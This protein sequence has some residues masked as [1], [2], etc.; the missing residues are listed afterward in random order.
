MGAR[1]SLRSLLRHLTFLEEE[2]AILDEAVAKKAE[3][4]RY[5][6]AVERLEAMPGIRVLTAMIFLTELGDMGRFRNRRQVGGILGL[7]PSSNESGEITDRKGHITRYGSGRL[8]R[9]LC[10]AVWGRIKQGGPDRPF[11]DRLVERNPKKKMIA[12]VAC[13][14]KLGVKM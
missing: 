7:V 6:Q 11:Y 5:R 4:P 3:L 2:S 8:R 10:Q 9:V 14:R 1:Q 13:M 12:V